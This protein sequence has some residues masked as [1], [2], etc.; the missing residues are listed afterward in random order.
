MNGGKQ[1]DQIRPFERPAL[2]RYYAWVIFAVWWSVLPA[3]LLAIPAILWDWIFLTPLV[4]IGGLGLGVLHVPLLWFLRCPHCSKPVTLQTFA[5]VH[6]RAA[7]R[8]RGWFEGWKR[9][10]LDAARGE[11]FVCMH[12][13][14]WVGLAT[15][16]HGRADAA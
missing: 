8:D 7:A 14:N 16:R 11:D 6:P 12:C 1:T 4:L 2:L 5:P 10:I 13:G 3:V 15:R 9:I